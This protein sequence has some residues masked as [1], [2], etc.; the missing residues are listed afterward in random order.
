MQCTPRAMCTGHL[1]QPLSNYFDHLLSFI[2]TLCVLVYDV[3]MRVG[4]VLR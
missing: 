3:V 1:V 4:W 2:T